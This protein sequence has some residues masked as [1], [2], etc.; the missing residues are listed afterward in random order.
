MEICN[1]LV[2]KTKEGLVVADLLAEVKAHKEH[3]Y[4]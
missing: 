3:L 2:D 4:N 1:Y